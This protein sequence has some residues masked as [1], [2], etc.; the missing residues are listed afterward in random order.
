MRGFYTRYPKLPKDD[1]RLN[2]S[3]YRVLSGIKKADERKA[4][5]DLTKE[6]AWNTDELQ[7]EVIR[8][9]TLPAKESN[10]AKKNAAK[11]IQPTRGRVFTYKIV[12]IEGCEKKFFDCGFKVCGDW[13]RFV[14]EVTPPRAGRAESRPFGV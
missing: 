12:E 10:G 8:R 14:A 1:A 6:N 3:H 2:W 9:K 4:L 13:G 5:E 7:E 11:K